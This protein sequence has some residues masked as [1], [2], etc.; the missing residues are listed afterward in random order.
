MRDQTRVR[1]AFSGLRNKRKMPKLFKRMLS[2]MDTTIVGQ[3]R[4]NKTKFHSVYYGKKLQFFRHRCGCRRRRRR[5]ER[6]HEC[7][8]RSY[9][10]IYSTS[11]IFIYSAKRCA[12]IF[13]VACIISVYESSNFSTVSDTRLQ[14]ATM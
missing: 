2:H 1:L 12:L 10:Q 11:C 4:M 13:L 7:Q 3:M 6:V 5:D 8:M 14:T 9:G